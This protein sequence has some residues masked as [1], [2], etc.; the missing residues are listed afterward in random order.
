MKPSIPVF[1]FSVSVVLLI[2]MLAACLQQ[3]QSDN[4]P[5]LVKKPQSQCNFL[6]NK[7]Q[8]K[9]L[10][11]MQECISEYKDED[12]CKKVILDSIGGEQ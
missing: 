7:V 9:C 8:E 3:A 2:V 11:A 12:L 6:D 5:V 4:A 10:A 1:A